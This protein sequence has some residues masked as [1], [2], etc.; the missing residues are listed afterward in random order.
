M[1]LNPFEQLRLL[2]SVSDPGK[3]FE[4][5]IAILLRD[6]GKTDGQV[7]IH[8]GDGG[9]DS[10]QGTFGKDGELVVYQMKYFPDSWKSSQK[11]DI[12]EAFRT[13]N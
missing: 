13:A 9:I 4:D 5:V 3:A 11:Q 1:A 12:R 7:K 10:Y 8:V 2:N 6:H